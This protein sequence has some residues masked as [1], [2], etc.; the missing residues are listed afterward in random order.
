MHIVA[1]SF[2]KY[3]F[4]SLVIRVNSRLVIPHS[5]GCTRS[6]CADIVFSFVFSY[7]LSLFFFLTFFS[8]HLEFW[9]SYVIFNFLSSFL[10]IIYKHFVHSLS[11]KCHH[12]LIFENDLSET[13]LCHSTATS[14]LDSPFSSLES[15]LNPRAA[16]HTRSFTIWL[17]VF[18]PG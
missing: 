2:S 12:I 14:P 11:Y 7:I 13:R 8:L 5:W 3:I 10:D 15:N 4:R 9:C 6:G 17:P 1:F 16:W 18:F